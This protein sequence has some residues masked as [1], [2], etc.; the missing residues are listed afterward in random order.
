[1]STIDPVLFGGRTLFADSLPPRTDTIA[2]RDQF[3]PI[4]LGENLVLNYLPSRGR[5]K[6]SSKITEPK[7]NNCLSIP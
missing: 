4:A 3:Q 5:G 7:A 1:M 2:P 6:Y